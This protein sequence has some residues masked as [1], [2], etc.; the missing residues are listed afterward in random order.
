[1][2]ARSHLKWEIG[3]VVHVDPDADTLARLATGD[4]AILIPA[5]SKNDAFGM[6]FGDK[7]MYFPVAASRTA[8]FSCKLN[9][10]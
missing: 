8:S 6:T 4:H 7:P 9:A 1:M 5:T 10:N 3:D 2:M